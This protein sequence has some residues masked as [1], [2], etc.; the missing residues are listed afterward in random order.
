MPAYSE[1][2]KNVNPADPFILVDSPWGKIEQWRASTLA[3]GTMGC[4]QTVYEHVKND[5]AELQ[6][7]KQEHASRENATRALSKD[8]VTK[9]DAITQRITRL[10]EAAQAR[11]QE[12]QARE[13]QRKPEDL[14][15][16]EL[17]P[18]IE[19][20]G[21]G[22]PVE[23]DTHHPTGDLHSVDPSNETNAEKH[24]ALRGDD[25]TDDGGV[26]DLPNELLETAPP[27][28]GNYPV[29]NPAKL[30]RPQSPTQRAPVGLSF[31]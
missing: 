16:I 2:F 28:E 11:E 3:L 12:A 23:D 4:L 6:E 17:P 10:E 31:W 5:S 20:L 13:D 29:N 21:E 18:G 7:R 19:E 22:D 24:A 30:N 14:E 8:V 1:F 15:N 26:G 27:E 9:I 25:S